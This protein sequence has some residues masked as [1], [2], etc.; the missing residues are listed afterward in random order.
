MCGGLYKNGP[1]MSIGRGTSRR[2]GFAGGSVSLGVALTLS[3]RN[4]IPRF[5]SLQS[6]ESQE[7][8][9]VELSPASPSPCLQHSAILRTVTIMD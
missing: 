6:Q 9:H 8:L 2:N 4:T 3:L 7:D 1:H 5:N